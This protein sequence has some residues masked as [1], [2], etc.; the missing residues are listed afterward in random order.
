MIFFT[1]RKCQVFLIFSVLQTF[2][3]PNASSAEKCKIGIKSILQSIDA[4]GS[5]MKTIAHIQA[6]SSNENLGFFV[7]PKNIPEPNENEILV[8]VKAVSVNPVDYKRRIRGAGTT[9]S[10]TQLGYDAAGIVE[11]IGSRVNNFKVGDRVYYAGDVR[12]PG[13]HSEYHAV[14]SRLVG[15]APRTLNFGEAAALPLT[16]LTAYEALFEKMRISQN[17]ALNSGKKILIIGGAGGVGSIAI[18]LAKLSGLEV[19]ATASRD[20]S[21]R[22]TRTMGADFILTSRDNLKQELLDKGIGPEF[23]YILNTVDTDAYWQQSAEL[24]KPFGQICSIVPPKNPVDLSILMQKSI[25]FHFELMFTKSTFETLDRESQSQA[26]DQIAEWI[27]QG[28]IKSTAYTNLGKISPENLATAHRL[29]ESGKSIGKIVLSEWGDTV[30]ESENVIRVRAFTSG[31]KNT[32][33]NPAGVYLKKREMSE[34]EMQ[35][36]S[37]KVGLSE[38]AFISKIPYEN[39]FKIDFFTPTSRVPDCGHAT[40]AAFS[41]IKKNFPDLTETTKILANGSLRKIQFQNNRITMV[42]PLAEFITSKIPI[43]T[44]ALG[45]GLQNTNPI[46]NI[47]IGKN[48]TGFLLIEVENQEF[49]KDI[50]PNLK[51]LKS[52]TDELNL[53]GVYVYVADTNKKDHYLSRMFG[54]SVGIEEESAT[55]MAAALLGNYLNTLKLGNTFTIEQGTFMPKPSTSEIIVNVNTHS[56]EVEISGL[57]SY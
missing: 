27:D 55:G 38:T 34:S 35:E 2:F 25:S 3:G 5:L 23:D 41:V 51:V 22:W 26:L 53:I 8:G 17:P 7:H 20:E 21:I 46:K 42:Q 1:K 47:A 48:S 19:V 18:Q 45:L 4:R 31:S 57:S 12:K 43:S 15:H 56:K 36:I 40:I 32:G 13:N 44:L 24:T 39:A 28:L 37:K 52:W 54:P 29:L 6:H 30:D 50:K 10:P 9:E 49:L 11:K 16:S 33:G 14:D